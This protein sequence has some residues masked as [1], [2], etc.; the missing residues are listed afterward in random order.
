MNNVGSIQTG[1]IIDSMHQPG[2]SSSLNIDEGLSQG[3][4]FTKLQ[5][6]KFTNKFI[7]PSILI[8]T[9]LIATIALIGLI[10]LLANHSSIL[11]FNN[12]PPIPPNP[13]G[14]HWWI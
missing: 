4:K 8:V 3:R 6:R 9:G 12:P 13:Y 2:T 1:D 10:I 14:S 7:L 5:D 11:G